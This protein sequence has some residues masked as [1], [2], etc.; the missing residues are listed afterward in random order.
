MF[1][2]RVS[3]IRTDQSNHNSKS[4]QKKISEG[5]DG[6][7]KW[8]KKKRKKKRENAGDALAIGFSFALTHCENGA[9]ILDQSQSIG[10]IAAT[11]RHSLEK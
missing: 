9:N 2:D 11:F 10:K 4:E 3:L 7:S 5:G 8:K 6:N 1:F